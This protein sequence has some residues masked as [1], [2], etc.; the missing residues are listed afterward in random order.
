MA[1]PQAEYEL[2][3]TLDSP[4]DEVVAEL[5]A[6]GWNAQKGVRYGIPYLRIRRTGFHH[7]VEYD[8]WGAFIPN[9]VDIPTD[10][11]PESR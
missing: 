9:I 11:L 5:K 2:G 6:H 8:F 4:I 10:F 7:V 1:M 3:T